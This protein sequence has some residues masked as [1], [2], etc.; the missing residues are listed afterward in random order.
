MHDRAN[1]KPVPSASYA[2]EHNGPMV[3]LESPQRSPLAVEDKMEMTNTMLSYLS[4][5]VSSGNPVWA[6]LVANEYMGGNC[7]LR[8]ALASKARQALLDSGSCCTE[9]TT[10]I[11]NGAR[12]IDLPEQAR[13]LVV[14]TAQ[15]SNATSIMTARRRFTASLLNRLK[16]EQSGASR[17]T[18]RRTT[19]TIN[20]Q[21]QN[22]RQA[23]RAPF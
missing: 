17:L 3:A 5:Q 6:V 1:K 10:A 2:Y 16:R 9:T 15:R 18:T 20:F 22:H 12:L 8:K 7:P 4:V 13:S 19:G 23:G 21:A 11:M 14:A